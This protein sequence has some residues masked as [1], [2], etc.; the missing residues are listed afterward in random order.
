MTVTPEER[1]QWRELLTYK[2]LAV[3]CPDCGAASHVP[4]TPCHGTK[5]EREYLE[6][7]SSH[8]K[9][10]H[11]SFLMSPNWA[12]VAKRLLDAMDEADTWQ[13]GEPPQDIHE[14]LV[15]EPHKIYGR[16]HRVHYEWSTDGLGSYKIYGR[17]HRVDCEWSVD[18]LGPYPWSPDWLWMSLPPPPDGK[19]E[20]PDGNQ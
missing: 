10:I 1:A 2:V 9:R 18:G 17:G 6:M 16:G 8:E 4:C 7:G 20:G 19:K 11:A 13:S 3:A 15:A 14:I 12:D 5:F